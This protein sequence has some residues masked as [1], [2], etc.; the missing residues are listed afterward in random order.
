MVIK[1][2]GWNKKAS[3]KLPFNIFSTHLV[4]PQEGH[5]RFVAL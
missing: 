5:W 4:P 3:L 2:I 1:N